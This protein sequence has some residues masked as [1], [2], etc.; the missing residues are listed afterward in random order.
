[1]PKHDKKNPGPN[2]TSTE[3][4]TAKK[5]EAAVNATTLTTSA[6]NDPKTMT[7]VTTTSTTPNTTVI[8]VNATT[9]L[10]T[11]TA[12]TLL[13]PQHKAATSPLLE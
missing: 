11:T 1:M 2:I 13:G 10:S 8:V 12:E 7:V 5:A 6:T 3:N 4:P 9:T